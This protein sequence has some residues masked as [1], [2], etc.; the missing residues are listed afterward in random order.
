M[1]DFGKIL[2]QWDSSSTRKQKKQTIDLAAEIDKYPVHDK[3]AEPEASDDRH[4]SPERVRVDDSI[5]LHG[6][7][8]SEAIAATDAFLSASLASGH[9]KVLVIHGKGRDGDGVLRKEIRAYLER[10]ERTGA[11]GHPKG[12]LGGRG[13]LWVMLRYRSR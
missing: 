1:S 5:D 11:M 10:H 13:A 3:D 12:E 2:D 9:R 8:V 7:T 4:E 6:Y